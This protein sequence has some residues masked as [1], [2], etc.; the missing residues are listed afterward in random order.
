MANTTWNS[1]PSA[2]SD[3][4]FRAWGSAMSAALAAVG[5]V[6]TADTGQINWTTVTRPSTSS[7][8]GYEV[9]RFPSS[10]HSTS[11]LY[12][13]ISYGTS[14]GATIPRY[15]IQT[16]S[17]TDGAGT[18]NGTTTTAYSATPL[19]AQAASLTSYMSCDGDG[20]AIMM[21][22]QSS[23]LSLRRFTCIERIRDSAGVAYSKAWF[24][25]TWDMSSNG[26]FRVGD[27]DTNT[28]W[29]SGFYAPCAIPQSAVT[30][31]QSY[32]YS[33]NTL[34]MAWQPGT[35]RMIGTSKMALTYAY[36]DEPSVGTGVVV[37][38]CGAAR[39]YVAGGS[40]MSPAVNWNQGAQSY[41]WSGL[42][43]WTD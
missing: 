7:I 43:W 15:D 29:N 31:G 3:A 34:S 22:P 19:A 2:S 4:E 16:G 36:T 42:M 37:T 20:L 30:A 21:W 27:S 38:H 17:G 6:Q 25:A 14:T 1:Q 41:Q 26:Y 13:K 24:H 8:G 35:R 5:M 40:N 10:L 9:W 32:L 33:G 28:A 18:L 12:V 39:T 11:P 23:Q